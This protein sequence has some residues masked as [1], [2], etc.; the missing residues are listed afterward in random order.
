M[1]CP[2]SHSILYPFAFTVLKYDSLFNLPNQ[3]ESK[4][5]QKQKNEKSQT[6]LIFLFEN[7]TFYLVDI[8]DNQKLLNELKL[9]KINT[10]PAYI[11]IKTKKNIL[12]T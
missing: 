7:G 10:F 5:F 4:S 9:K 12:P 6:P 11:F 1:S 3:E 2:S 8:L